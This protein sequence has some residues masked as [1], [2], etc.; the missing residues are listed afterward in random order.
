MESKIIPLRPT[1]GQ[2]VLPSEF[3]HQMRAIEQCVTFLA[4]A[5][6]TLLQD[7]D[8]QVSEKQMTADERQ[9]YRAELPIVQ[10]DVDEALQQLRRLFE[11]VK[12]KQERPSA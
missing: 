3:D 11:T 1:G 4:E 2:W 6:D 5:T 9:F 12:Q 8:A 10:S 7:A